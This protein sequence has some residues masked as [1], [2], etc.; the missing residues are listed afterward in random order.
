RPDDGGL[1]AET[2]GTQYGRSRDD[3]GNWFGNNN[4]NPLWHFTLPERYLRRNPYVPP[5]P[6]RVPVP[7]VP[8]AAPIFPITRTLPRL[9]DPHT[10]N[11]F[12]SACSP[13]VYRDD[14]FG[15]EFA[16]NSFVSEPVHNLVHREV[17][18]P[19]GSTFTSRRAADE[20]RSEFLTSSDNWCRPT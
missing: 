9:N 2:G 8:G 5:P 1:E 4:S 10:A 17:M 16:N 13:I 19:R 15:P 14:L 20:Q 3:W 11:H 12:T 6:L 18:T 7:V